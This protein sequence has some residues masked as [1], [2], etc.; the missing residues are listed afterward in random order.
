M[1]PSRFPNTQWSLVGR[2][3]A[4]DDATRSAAIDAVLRTYR[5]GLL[6][7]LIEARR[8]P[9]DAADDLLQDFIT[10]KILTKH[11]LRFADRNRGKFRNFLLI[12][13]NHF[14]T[15]RMRRQKMK[16]V[17]LDHADGVAADPEE[18]LQCFEREWVNQVIRSA[19]TLMQTECMK[20]R[21]PDLWEIFRLRVAEPALHGAEPADYANLIAR[22]NLSSPRQ[23]INLLASSKRVFTRHLRAAIGQYVPADGDIDE[24]IADLRKIC[25]R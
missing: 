2:A 9:R 25:V 6:R 11:L 14:V 4:L 1:K 15:S 7:F 20:Q 10:E 5:P 17:D 19:L 12:S 8:L 3:S 16:T 21:R 24:E 23:A 22:F 13:L 18:G